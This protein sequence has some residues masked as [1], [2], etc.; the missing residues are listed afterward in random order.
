MYTGD[1]VPDEVPLLKGS[2]TARVMLR[3][4]QMGLLEKLKGTCLVR[5]V[6]AGWACIM[7]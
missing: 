1:A 2:Y 6:G 4:E 5:G 3:H 7:A